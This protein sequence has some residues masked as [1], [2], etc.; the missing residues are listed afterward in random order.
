MAAP[1]CRLRQRRRNARSQ[2]HP[3]ASN[4]LRNA[5]SDIR[6]Q[7]FQFRISVGKVGDVYVEAVHDL[8]F[9]APESYFDVLFAAGSSLGTPYP[10]YFA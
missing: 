5:G 4:I 2:S 7:I 1:A 10:T 3:T 9:S 6:D 8:L